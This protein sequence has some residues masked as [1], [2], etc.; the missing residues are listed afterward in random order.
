MHIHFLDVRAYNIYI[1]TRCEESKQS[2]IILYRRFERWKYPR[3][4]CLFE[5]TFQETKR[6]FFKKRTCVM[7]FFGNTHASEDAHSKPKKRTTPQSVTKKRCGNASGPS[8]EGRETTRARGED[9]FVLR[10]MFIK[11]VLKG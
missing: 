8:R 11:K 5:A 10:G 3:D 9:R 2:G 1:Y 7:R 4:I 6:R